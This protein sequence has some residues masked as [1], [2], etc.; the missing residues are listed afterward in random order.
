M[1]ATIDAVFPIR[2][3]PFVGNA[4]TGANATDNLSKLKHVST[5][6]KAITMPNLSRNTP[7]SARIE[8]AA[9]PR[10]RETFAIDLS[11]TTRQPSC[12]CGCSGFLGGFPTVKTQSV[13]KE[14]FHARDRFYRK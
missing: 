1:T 13:N 14:A 4:Q 11:E 7:K 12:A 8:S 9:R 6:S 10:V 2:H 3:D 5:A